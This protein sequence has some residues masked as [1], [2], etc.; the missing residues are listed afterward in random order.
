MF[1]GKF[2][3]VIHFYRKT[4]YV[5]EVQTA[6]KTEVLDGMPIFIPMFRIRGC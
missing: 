2:H 3:P 5:V 6:G 1:L 4:L